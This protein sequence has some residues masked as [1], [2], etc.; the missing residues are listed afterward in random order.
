[1]KCKLTMLLLLSFV[2]A[3]AQW[4]NTTNQFYDSLHM[5]IC[6]NLNSQESSI[7]LRSY[8]DSGYIIIWQDDRTSINNIDIYAQKLDKYGVAL[9][10][11]NG[12]PIATGPDVQAFVR[13]GNADYRSYGHA[14]TDSSGGFYIAWED[15]NLVNTGVNGAHRVC[16]Q[17][18]KADGTNVFS[19]LGYI[20]NQ[21]TA[22]LPSQYI[23][24][25]LIADGN[26]GFYIA[27]LETDNAS[28][29]FFNLRVF[30]YRE[31][32]GLLKYYGGQQID[33][34]VMQVNANAFPCG[35]LVLRKDVV[36]VDD[37]VSEF[38]IFPDNNKGCGIVWTFGRNAAAPNNGGYLVYNH[39]C[40]VKKD[41]YVTIK[42]RFFAG[43]LTDT[44]TQIIHGFFKKD[45]VYLLYNKTLY[46]YSDIYL[47]NPTG[48][49]IVDNLKFENGGAGYLFLESTNT[50]PVQAWSFPKGVVLATD[51][52]VD[53][54]IITVNERQFLNNSLTGQ[55]TRAYVTEPIE[56][57]DSIP[58]QW[59]SDTTHPYWAFNTT[60]PLNLNKTNRFIDTIMVQDIQ[61]NTDYSLASGKN[62]AFLVCK[63]FNG[64][65][66]AFRASDV[67][68]QEV[69]VDRIN[70]DSF[71]IHINTNSKK[72][73]LVAKEK[74]T[75]CQTSDIM[76]DNPQIAMD[77]NGN[78]LFYMTESGR[79]IRV[80][81]I[82]DS[83]KLLWGA[84][85]KPIGNSSG[86]A[87]PFVTM[88]G[89]GT[90]LV[91]WQKINYTPVY[92]GSDIYVR[93]LDSLNVYA[94]IPPI[95]KIR[96]LL[97]YWSG[98]YPQ[99]LSG[100][101]TVWISFEVASNNYW[102]EA[103]QVL[104]N[105][106][107]GDVNFQAFKNPS[108]IRSFNGKP[109]LDRN[110][111]I[112]VQN[113]PAGAASVGVRLFFTQAEFDA[114]KAADPTIIS[115]ADLQVI[116]QP[117]TTNA[118]E[119]YLPVTGEETITPTDWK[120]VDGGYYLEIYVS[121]FSNF[122][123]FKGAGTLPLRWL[124]VQA[125]WTDDT[126]A[127]VRWEIAD[128]INV[129]SYTVEHSNDGIHFV[130]V[131]D[132]AATNNWQYQCQVPATKGK[133]NFYRIKQKDANGQTSYSKMVLLTA[134]DALLFVKIYPNPASARV[135]VESNEIVSEV[136]VYDATGRLCL[137]QNGHYKK[138]QL[139]IS[140]LAKGVYEVM[141]KNEA[142]ILKN[143]KLIIQ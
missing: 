33:P 100:L 62:R 84:A 138:M 21:P 125:K 16:V 58:Y 117:S 8:P 141:V 139:N 86:S 46:S 123:I 79:Y 74:S 98:A 11:S 19:N 130:N 68:L 78:A 5:P 49:G 88:G 54:M 59:A 92:T 37:R 51:G 107:L 76:F 36:P 111:L 137:Q 60:P 22:S 9:W 129:L 69:R 112:N 20:V 113:N 94:H 122:F 14:C 110:Y 31:E 2:I 65:S 50:L 39:L 142:G 97:N 131:C 73:T 143:E 81:P 43:S 40:R 34:D 35:I 95:K 108:I 28:A 29:F 38:H 91:G 82:G 57:Y 132:V 109:Y 55:I 135:Q 52:N 24:P 12:V 23:A 7:V 26:K 53:A 114:L 66:F 45:D 10:A 77:A 102:T 80:S 103:V 25:Q 15:F 72:G 4:S 120:A 99:I 116:K 18:T 124:D 134:K 93:H 61:V 104:D 42:K 101:T 47:C 105:F 48:V 136:K 140:H 119:T 83:A 133:Q 115:P 121:S 27:Y 87:F 63:K 75:C 30:C 127:N 32:G 89:D 6:S 41:S 96:P 64:N 17:H 3:E 1:M 118:P 71:N 128:P 44:S 67:L 56:K 90:A 106:N 70:A 13:N 85:G 126:H